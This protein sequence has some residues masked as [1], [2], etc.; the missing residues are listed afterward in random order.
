MTIIIYVLL[1]IAA[2]YRKKS[3]P[4]FFLIVSFMWIMGTFCV[5]IADQS[6]YLSR[7]N[8]P[9]LW[10]SITEFGFQALVLFV[11]RLG[12]SYVGLRGV[13]TA[14]ELLLISSTVL[15][16]SK[17]PNLVMVMYALCP[18][19]LN[20]AQMRSAL[21]TSIMI[22]AIRFI[23]DENRKKTKLF[24]LEFNDVMYCILIVG[25]T[26][27]HTEAIMW[28]VLLLAKKFDLKKTVVFT[29]AFNA[30]VYFLLSPN[31]LRR[32]FVLF[33]AGTRIS[34]YLSTEY[35][36]SEWKHR[37][38]VLYVIFAVGITVLICY[39]AKRSRYL[40]HNL[41]E[42]IKRQI[43]LCVKMN[44]LML[45]TVSVILRYTGDASRIQEGLSVLN[46]MFITNYIVSR[47][48][49]MNRIKM[50]NL[51]VAMWGGVYVLGYLWLT[52]LHYLVNSV[53]VPY[54]FNNTILSIF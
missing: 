51:K 2:I 16:Y 43:D 8:H 50:S 14:I 1:A 30:V 29:V 34:A 33:G 47:G 42:D 23:L 24:K 12:L 27:I 48:F 11:K 25:A 15:K 20:V 13:I 39:V 19:P 46:Y 10:T 18:F 3:R 26:L 49:T 53:W 32:L 9:E 36:L 45:C 38:P 17:Y 28:I 44:I 54:W 41:T 4:L 6:V 52:I 31:V 22:F 7:F 5:G 37:G 40:Q 21:A 35:A